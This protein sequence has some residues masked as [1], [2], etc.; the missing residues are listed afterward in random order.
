M[1]QRSNR[2]MLGLLVI[3]TISTIY[4][5]AQ[6]PNLEAKSLAGSSASQIGHSASISSI[7]F[8]PD[9]K[10]VAT[11]SSDRTARL[12]HSLDRQENREIDSAA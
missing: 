1:I 9:G 3:L 4:T 2:L 5:V 12:W 6:N 10:T 11:G 7:A 8:S